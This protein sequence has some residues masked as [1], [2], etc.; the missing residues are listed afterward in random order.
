MTG[1]WITQAKMPP[2]LKTFSSPSLTPCPSTAIRKGYGPS[3]VDVRWVPGHKGITGNEI[4]DELA[5]AGAE[6]GEV[7]NEGLATLAHSRRLAKREARTDFKAW[8]AANK[9]ESYADYR[10]ALD[11]GAKAFFGPD[12]QKG[13]AKLQM[14]SYR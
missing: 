9:P 8:W 1:V 3:L 14:C 5:K 10:A 2:F 13:L 7:V 6:G 12:R 11:K 4:A